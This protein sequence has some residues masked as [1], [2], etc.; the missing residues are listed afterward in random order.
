LPTRASRRRTPLNVWQPDFFKAANGSRQVRAASLWKTYLRWHL[1]SAAAPTLSKK[2]VD[3]NFASTAR[4]SRAL[5]RTSRAGSAAL[6]ATDNA[7]GM[8]LGRIYVKEYFPPEAKEARWT[9]SSETSSS[10]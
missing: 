7:M 9:S 6:S 4:R 10:P 5:R 1:L 3:E 8:A 2:F